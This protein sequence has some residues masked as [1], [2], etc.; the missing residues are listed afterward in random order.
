[1]CSLHSKTGFTFLL[2]LITFES[3]ELKQS[4]IP[5]LKV[6]V[7]G[8]NAFSSQWCG[9]IFILCYTHLKLALLLHKTAIVNFLMSTTVSMNTVV[10]FHGVAGEI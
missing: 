5:H 1:M 8:I 10:E 4:F 6:L 2:Y 3:I 7:C 9:C